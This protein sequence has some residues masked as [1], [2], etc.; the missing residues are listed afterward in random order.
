MCFWRSALAA[1]RA[2]LAVSR[3]LCIYFKMSSSL[4]SSLG[5]GGDKETL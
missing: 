4:A 5:F 2:L 1:S 3:Q